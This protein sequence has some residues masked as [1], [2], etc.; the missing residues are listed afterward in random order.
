MITYTYIVKCPECED[1][2]FDFF[3]EA[4]EFALGCLTKK[5]IIT[6]TEVTRNDFGECTDHC[7]LGTIWSWEDMM[8]DTE[9]EDD[10]VFSKDETFGISEDLDDFDDFD[11]GPQSDEFDYID[12][13]VD[14]EIED[15]PLKEAAADE[16]QPGVV[17]TLK[18]DAFIC[19]AEDSSIKGFLSNPTAATI[20]HVKS[21]YTKGEDIIIPKGTKLRFVKETLIHSIWYCMFSDSKVVFLFS[22]NFAN[23]LITEAVE[24]RKLIPKD[25]TIEQLVEEMEENEDMVECKWCEELFPKEEGRFEIGFGGLICRD[26]QNAAAS[27]GEQMAYKTNTYW[28]FLDE[29]LDIDFSNCVDSS[30]LEIWGLNHV[31]EDIYKAVL[32]KRFKDVSFRGPEDELQKVVDKMYDTNGMFTFSFGKNGLPALNSWNVNLLR[33]LGSIRIDFEDSRYEDAVAKVFNRKATNEDFATKEIHDLGNEYDGGYPT[34]PSE[35]DEVS[36]SHL[37]L[38][39]E[40]GKETF[41]IETGICVECGFN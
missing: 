14:F 25:M 31:Q 19:A 38:C 39:P 26:C 36:D 28:D 41:D 15:E 6:Q 29:K 4:K 2:F 9:S 30:D 23:H 24:T 3:D 18:D 11:I 17:Y 10:M 12:N 32:L 16:L 7:D 27:R 13:S 21:T 8:K 34:E 37:K 22:H 40:C 1:E 20:A 33:K 5:P 35:I